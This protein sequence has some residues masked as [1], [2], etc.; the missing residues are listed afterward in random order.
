[1]KRSCF[2]SKIIDPIGYYCVQH[3]RTPSLKPGGHTNDFAPI[4]GRRAGIHRSPAENYACT[5][6]RR[7][8]GRRIVFR[9]RCVNR[10]AATVNRGEIVSL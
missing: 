10:R 2:G 1:M 5:I 3:F 9:K 4:H 8:K 6:V 7:I